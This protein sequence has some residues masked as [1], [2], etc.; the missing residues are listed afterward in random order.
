M[1]AN[2]LTDVPTVAAYLGQDP[3]QDAALLQTLVTAVST[4]IQARIGYDVAPTSYTETRSGT[5]GRV[6]AFAYGPVTDVTSLTIDRRIISAVTPG[7]AVGYSFDS[8]AL[9]LSGTVFPRGHRN[10][11]VTYTAG[12]ET[13][14]ADLAEAAVELV[15]LRYRLRDKA[16]LVS[17]SG[18][19]QTTSYVQKDMPDSVATA[20]SPYCRRLSRWAS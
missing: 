1:N 5:D 9:Y 3:S 12:Y 20:L 17:E 15:A 19:Q 14:P 6:F 11:S 16:G 10:V 18:L 13:V 4:F 2:D 8:A 7:S